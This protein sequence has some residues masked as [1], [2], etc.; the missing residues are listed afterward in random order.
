MSQKLWTT[1]E[2]KRLKE[3]HAAGLTRVQIAIRM[4]RTVSSVTRR[5]EK[6]GLRSLALRYWSEAEDARMRAL[7]RN[8]FSAAQIER[9]IGRSEASIRSRLLV[10]GVTVQSER[11]LPRRIAA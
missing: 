7:I 11:G 1:I 10:L 9:E 6:L 4:G 8:G 2:I 3:L 5:A